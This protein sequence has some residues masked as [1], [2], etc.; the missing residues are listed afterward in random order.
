MGEEIIISL[1]LENDAPTYNLSYYWN[2]DLYW[3]EKGKLLKNE[4]EKLIKL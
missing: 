1:S 2:L 4:P 3:P